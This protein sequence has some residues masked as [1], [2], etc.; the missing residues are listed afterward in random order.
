MNRQK[1]VRLLGM[2]FMVILLFTLLSRGADG[3][4]KAG[5]QIG[6][7]QNRLIVHSVTG[8]GKVEG[9]EVQAVFAPSGRRVQKLY[10]SEGQKV[11]KGEPL[12]QV[13]VTE[14]ADAIHKL[15]QEVQTLELTKSDLENSRG[16][17]EEEKQ[18]AVERAEQDYQLTLEKGD[19]SI[20]DAQDNYQTGINKLNAMCANGSS[21]EEIQAQRE[22]VNALRQSLNQTII[23][24]ND[25]VK[26]AERA[27]EDARKE[28]AKDSSLEKT[29]LELQ[30]KR[31]ELEELCILSEGKGEILCPEDGLL[32]ALNISLGGRTSDEA[33]AILALSS[34]SFRVKGTAAAEQE[35]YL[36]EGAQAVLRKGS[37]TIEGAVVEE[38][39]K[40]TDS[41]LVEITLSIPSK[42][43][44][45]GDLVEFTV[46]VQEGPYASCIPLE[47]LHEDKG[48]SFVYV[49]ETASSVLGEELVARKKSV[50]VLDKNESFAALSQGGLSVSDKIIISSD[51]EIQNGSRVRVEEGE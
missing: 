4:T 1:I 11:T 8:S 34:G 36:S 6:S 42:E 37:R 26:A 16:L 23:Q 18:R 25:S 51:R 29:A 39:S 35:K 48:E 47:A 28:S 5:V 9:C 45:L 14:L 2:F 41:S 7:I 3:L 30:T 10:V 44:N 33:A 12:F 19:I 49:L 32:T 22:Q 13:D 40:N 21:A 31:K 17:A 20:G 27:L 46:S 24:R 15:E 50:Q 43:V 38:L